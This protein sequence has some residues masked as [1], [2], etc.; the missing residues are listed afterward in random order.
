MGARRDR[1]DAAA[2]GRVAVPVLHRLRPVQPA[3]LGGPAQLRPDVHRGPALLALRGDHTD[4]RR[5]RRAPATRPRAGRRA[6]PEVHETRQGLLPVR[7]LR[8]VT[9]RRVDVDRPRLA[10]DLQRRRHG[11]QPA[12]HRRLGQ[13]AGLGV[14]GRGAADGVAVRGADGHLPRGPPADP[15][16]AVRGGGRGRRREVAAVPVRHGAH[17]VPGPV[18]QPRPADHPGL[19]GLHAR[20]RDRRRQGRPRRLDP[21]LHPVPLR[22]RLRRLPHGLRLRHGLGAADRH[23][24]RHR[25]AVPHL[26]LLGLLRLRGDR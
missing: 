9:A 26:A 20:L 21:R 13:Q 2:D 19:P 10:R 1:P 6:R 7:V 11:G 24:R 18:L 23:R 22:S 5:H 15:G 25:G 14:A 17:A 3:A 16:R 8:P 12:R 4:V